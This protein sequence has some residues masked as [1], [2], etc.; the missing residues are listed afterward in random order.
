MG[1]E[2]GGVFGGDLGQQS[3]ERYGQ[4]S[5][6]EPVGGK[7]VG[8]ELVWVGEVYLHALPLSSRTFRTPQNTA[9]SKQKLSQVG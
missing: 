1:K 4:A 5:L 6:P 7:L 3:F 8:K 9:C 2:R